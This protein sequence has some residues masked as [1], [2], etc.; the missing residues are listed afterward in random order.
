MKIR[1]NFHEILSDFLN[2][3]LDEDKLFVLP[4]KLFSCV[5]EMQLMVEASTQNKCKYH[6][7]IC[8]YASLFQREWSI[9]ELDQH[10]SKWRESNAYWNISRI[11]YRDI[12]YLGGKSFSADFNPIY[13]L[14]YLQ[15]L[16]LHGQRDATCRRIRDKFLSGMDAEFDRIRNHYRLMQDVIQTKLMMHEFAENH[17][18]VS[19]GL[20]HL[21]SLGD[22]W[23]SNFDA[24]QLADDVWFCRT[25]G[26]I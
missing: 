10:A 23:F 5:E 12:A 16:L 7:L 17:A 19:K 15:K 3:P 13:C 14:H 26:N 20:D 24:D 2:A 21:R 6:D 4:R 22:D 8:K 1:E 11:A 25:F 18:E 9:E